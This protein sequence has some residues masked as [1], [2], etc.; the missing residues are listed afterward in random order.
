MKNLQKLGAWMGAGAIMVSLAGC[1][2]SN[3]NGQPDGVATTDQVANSVGRGVDTTENALAGTGN[4][5]AK[6]ADTAVDKTGNALTGA[7]N[8]IAKGADSVGDAAGALVLTPK[9]KTAL[10][11][12]AAMKGSNINVD[13]LPDKTTIALRGTVTSAAQMKMAES[14]AKKMAPGYKVANQL[15]MAGK[16]NGG[17]M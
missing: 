7:G 1:T 4:A 13:T 14:M 9:I 5:I 8:A 16:T 6:G 17:K 12:N 11:N 10:G 2:D 3:N 15:K